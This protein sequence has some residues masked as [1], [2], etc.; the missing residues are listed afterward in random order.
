M[1]PEGVLDRV[2]ALGSANASVFMSAWEQLG[3]TF[4]QIAPDAK[5]VH[6]E[7]KPIPFV[8]ASL[9]RD[10]L[11]EEAVTIKDNP[12]TFSTTLIDR[13]EASLLVVKEVR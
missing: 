4:R 3:A 13:G 6:V 8:V 12:S 11:V 2:R 1:T 10:V 9:I 5:Q 7:S